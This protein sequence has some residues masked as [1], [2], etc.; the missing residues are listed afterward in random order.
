M[1]DAALR[2]PPQIRFVIGNEAL[3]RFAFNG[4]RSILTSYLVTFVVLPERDAKSWFHAFMM[5]T[6]LTPLVGGW[7][8]DR[9]LGRYATILRFSFFSIA[10]YL[11]LALWQSPAGVVLGAGLIA[12]GAGGILPCASAF[13]GEQLPSGDPG[14]LERVYGWF[15]WV[16][17]LGAAGANLAVPFLLQRFGPAVAFAAPSAAMTLATLV[18]WLGRRHYVASPPSGPKPH[19]FVRVVASA[20]RRIGTHRA[21]EHWL[22]AARDAHPPAAVEGAK[23]VLR[24]LGIF[25]SVTV[26]WALFDQT[27]SSWV[28]Q[29]EKMDLQLGA[30]E[31]A[32]A[33]LQALNPV[34]VML[35][36]PLFTVAVF[37]R[38]ERRGRLLTPLAKMRVGM[39]A[40]VLAFVAAAA[41]QM[42]L[43]A[44][45]A[46]SV[47]WQFPQYLLM[48]VGEV[49]VSVTGLEFSYT[50]AP[51]SM[52][53]AIMSIWF[54]TVFLGNLL[55]LSVLNLVELGDA[56]SLWFFAALMLAATVTFGAVERR[57]PGVH[58]P[59][60][61]SPP[62]N[63]GASV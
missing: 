25:A 48:T 24:V 39:A 44:G 13:I 34:L 28:I 18:F 41:L 60:R 63:A 47:L 14:L 16:I 36:V 23:A 61:G 2:Y 4:M 9:F 17:N 35:L 38:L 26:F 45:R 6:Y 33:Q 30:W 55:T 43:D 22:D 1:S 7:L 59:R 37:P 31:L 21:G 57:F 32:P 50:Q 51:R 11:T 53:S 58:P 49:L 8:A 46:P 20:V 52:R 5:A 3:E 27:G 15:Y 29:A 56:G 19:G 62:P 12:C 42:V 40:T 54:L 10:G